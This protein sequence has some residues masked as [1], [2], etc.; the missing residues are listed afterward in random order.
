MAK[1]RLE[2]GDAPRALEAMRQALLVMRLHKEPQDENERAE[3]QMDLGDIFMRLGMTED[4]HRAFERASVGTSEATLVRLA[5]LSFRY[6]LWQEA[7]AVLRRNV[8]LHPNSDLAHWNLAHSLAESWHMQEALES[9]AKAEAIAPQPG[10]KS[11]RASVAGRSGDADTALALYKAL[12]DEE[13]PGS[14]MHSSAAMS[15]LYSDK[16]SPQE[17]ADLHREMFAHLGQNT[18]AVSSFKS[19]KS[20]DR[21]LR[22]GLVSADF[23]HQHPVNIFMQPV[24]ARLDRRAVEVTMYFTG[25]SYDEQTQL[26]KRRV[27]RWVEATSWNDSQLSRRIEEDGID[28]LLDLSGHTSMQRMS[29]FGHRAAP[30]Q[31]T[32]LG[33]PG[34][35]GVPNIDWLIADKVVAPEGSE[36]LFSERLMRLPHSVFCFAPETDYPYPDYG[37]AHAQ[38]PLTFGSFNNVPKLTP[39][40]VKLWA[41]VLHEVPDSRLLLKAPSFKDEGAIEAFAE[42]FQTEGIARERLEFRGPVGLTD[43]MAEYA[44]V[45]IALDTVPYNGGTTSLQALWM[46]VP[47]VVKAGGNFV[48]RMGASFMSAAGL[49]DWVAKTDADYVRIASSMARDRQA[50]LALKRGLR[51]RLQAAPAWD[52]DQYTRD[53]ENALRQMWLAHVQSVSALGGKSQN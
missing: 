45:D 7:Q 50:L 9:L 23:H 53:F 8:E 44:D 42:R 13:G 12:A 17:V 49:N 24:L 22:V 39:H 16:L 4:G 25:V 51:Q 29:L 30:V 26:A 28:I 40:T 41:A 43:M 5:D 15:S 21:P 2:R 14:K 35:T 32:F 48:S 27:A 52:I 47:V 38:R 20:P 19:D 34:S 33:Y 6:N 37:Q 3:M 36:G 18:R 10:A 1:Y 46:G 31:A 11:M